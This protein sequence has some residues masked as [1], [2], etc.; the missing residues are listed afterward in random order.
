MSLQKPLFQ[1]SPVGRDR[2]WRLRMRFCKFRPPTSP[3]PHAVFLF[4]S[5]TRSPP[6]QRISR[7]RVIPLRRPR[8]CERMT[9]TIPSLR[10]HAAV[11]TAPAPSRSSGTQRCA[12]ARLAVHNMHAARRERQLPQRLCGRRHSTIPRSCS[13]SRDCGACRIHM[14][15]P[16]GT[17]RHRRSAFVIGRAR[18]GVSLSLFVAREGVYL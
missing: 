10:A 5:R 9:V 1:H 18:R 11:V 6:I 8:A 12:D 14:A 16:C 2:G 7:A 3:T 17:Q 4:V 13:R 15:K